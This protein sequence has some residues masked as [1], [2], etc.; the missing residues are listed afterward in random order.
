MLQLA[1][2]PTT[3]CYGLTYGIDTVVRPGQLGR[4]FDQAVYFVPD[5]DVRPYGPGEFPDTGV[6]VSA[7]LGKWRRGC[8]LRF[9]HKVQGRF[10]DM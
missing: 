8:C 9:G 1:E 7:S 2:A 6:P 3:S 10:T 4:D 5:P